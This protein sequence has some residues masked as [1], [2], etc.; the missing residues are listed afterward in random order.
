MQIRII[1]AIVIMLAA[2]A[3]VGVAA[4]AEE[5]GPEATAEESRWRLGAALGYGLR[6]NPLVQ[7][8]DIPIV[9]DFDIAWFGDHFFFDNGDLGL[10]LADN[11]ALTVSLIGRFNSDRVFFGNT[12]TRFV[13]TDLAGMPLSEAIEF[14]VPDRDYAIELGLELLMDGSWG[15]LQMTAFHDVSNT[16]E[17]FEV[18]IDYGYGWRNQRW[19]IEPSI[20]LSYKSDALNDY[21]WGVRDDEVSVVLPPYQ[22]DAGTNAHARLMVG[23]QIS[24]SW[25]FSLV[26]EFE[27]LNDN[28]AESPLVDEQDVLG[29]FAGFGFRFR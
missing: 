22:A 12:D 3:G 29:Y 10:T 9:V 6:S 27:R 21:Y 7:S 16:H 4:A 13:S 2:S 17:G 8:D 28:A 11:D 19:Y 15:R 5:T 26:A 20:G 24:R 25:T 18:Y 1:Q 23:Y 14:T